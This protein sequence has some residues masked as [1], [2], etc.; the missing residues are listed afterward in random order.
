MAYDLNGFDL[1]KLAPYTDQLA[2]KLWLDIVARNVT[3]EL[4]S[5]QLVGVETNSKYSVAINR[6]QI[7]P[8]AQLGGC[9]FN[10]LGNVALDQR[11][12]T[13]T[14]I[15]WEDNL[16]LETL[17][18]VWAGMYLKNAGVQD[19]SEDTGYFILKGVEEALA[20]NI[21]HQLEL[22]MWQGVTTGSLHFNTGSLP[23]WS[24]SGYTP[25]VN[26]SQ[27]NTPSN[28][29]DGW[30]TILGN[31]A[32]RVHPSNISGSYSTGLT[33]A[34]AYG[35]VENLLVDTPSEMLYQDNL[36]LFMSPA[37][38]IAYVGALKAEKFFIFDRPELATGNKNY[39]IV[40][41]GSDLTV[42]A[43]PGLVGSNAIIETF[44]DNLVIGC[45]N[46]ANLK[47]FSHARIWYSMDF[48]TMRYSIKNKIGVNVRYPQ[49]CITNF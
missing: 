49:W 17:E 10:P 32:S 26:A 22:G 43:I 44:G 31:E 19:E 12:I 36:T 13:V 4:A 16:C 29:F 41:P 39:A 14:P 34:N 40:H 23:V 1:S 2:Q 7:D 42:R 48:G 45:D 8:Q 25:L 33:V 3:F 6:L 28:I 20:K 38:Y 27:N 30:V 37:N 35:Y 18:Q 9:G 46:F 5:T 11:N 24:A 47:S 21:S 15:K